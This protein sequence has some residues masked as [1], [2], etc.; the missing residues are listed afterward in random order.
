MAALSAAI[1]AEAARI[2][3]EFQMKTPDAIQLATAKEGG[4]TSFLTND[5]EL[6]SIPGLRLIFLEQVR[7]GSGV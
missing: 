6:A 2:R 3:A 5:G 4:A 1:A 7:K